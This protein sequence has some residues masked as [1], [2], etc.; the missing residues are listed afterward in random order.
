M[1][2]L[3][4]FAL[5]LM[6]IG[7]AVFVI[8]E[9]GSGPGPYQVRAIFDDA[10][11]AVG[12]EEVRIAG[13]PVGTISSLSVTNASGL[14][15]A[16]SCSRVGS[17]C[18]AAVTL[19][20]D[21]S[22][23][24]PFRANATC[25]IRPQSLIG[26]KFVD[27][28]PGTSSAPPLPKIRR[29]P[30]AGTYL[31][32]VTHTSSPVDTDIVQDIYRE[33]VT[34]QFSIIINEL[35]TGLAARG[36][37]L[38]AVILRADPALGYTDQV[39]QILARQNRQLAQLAKDSD[40][41]LTPLAQVRK[42]IAD[43]VVNANTTSVAS[44]ARATDIARSFQLFPTFLRQLQPLMADLGALADQ[45]TPLFT[46]LNQSAKALAAQYTNLA[47][48][49]NVARQSLIALG[50][51]SVQQ[52]PAL[53]AT[54]PLD[55]QLLK[56]GNA[57][58]PSFTSLDRLTKSLDQTGAIQQLMGL[59]FYGT[60]ATNGFDSSGH[61]VRTEAL[62]GGCTGY[63]KTPVAGCSANFTHTGVA[64]D[65]A[66]VRRGS[67]PGRSAKATS[68]MDAKLARI[69]QDAHAGG[70]SSPSTAPLRGLLGYLI[71]GDQ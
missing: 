52:Q 23:F 45:G 8:E 20:I 4:L 46:S 51:S 60:E 64:A 1:R 32:P 7:I 50:A 42:Q 19:E 14:G 47:P 3:G 29:G 12:G 69:V 66:S 21:N 27:C 24:T 49:A 16:T 65:T 54:L 36:S 57:G 10:A 34:Q 58:V 67:A 62:V 37:D 6:V 28:N 53:L 44:A 9:A 22:A 17:E 68:P 40:T 2:L 31:L 43:W 35:G 48:F 41:V 30:G 18:K 61:Y 63:A 26:E 13:A 11:F 55:E 38:N 70:I 39:L 25:A 5:F 33:P 15:S 59:L 56:L 71:G